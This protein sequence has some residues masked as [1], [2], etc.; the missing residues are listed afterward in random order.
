MV[1]EASDTVASE[2]KHFKRKTQLYIFKVFFR[3]A[4]NCH[5]NFG[6]TEILVQGTNISEELV[7]ADRFF[8]VS[9]VL[10]ASMEGR[11]THNS[12]VYHRVRR[13]YK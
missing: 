8:S 11:S 3:V 2:Q 9:L 10:H 6:P 4:V 12:I 5:G 13:L 1:F 7:Q